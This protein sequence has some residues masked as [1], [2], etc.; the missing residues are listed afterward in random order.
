MSRAIALWFASSACV[1][2]GSIDDET[3]DNA[4]DPDVDEDEPIDDE[5]PSPV[6]G[7]WQG[8]CVGDVGMSQ[9]LDLAGALSLAESPPGVVNGVLA[10]TVTYADTTTTVT[11][12]GHGVFILGG[13][14]IGQDVRLDILG[15]TSTYV[16]GSPVAIPARLELT[17]DGDT[18]NG[19]FFIYSVY[20]VPCAFNR[21]T[22]R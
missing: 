9:S 3:T 13:T 4:T 8:A 19:D 7:V 5:P 2:S 17:L 11:S 21:L 1:E 20:A 6:D 18:L 22:A 12:T 10:Y 16:P 14:R 15:Y